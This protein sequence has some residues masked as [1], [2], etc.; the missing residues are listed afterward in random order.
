MSSPPAADTDDDAS[1]S[2]P[3]PAPSPS[4]DLPP[5]R[6][7]I[8]ALEQRANADARLPRVGSFGG[9]LRHRDLFA[10]EPDG[11]VSHPRYVCAQRVW[12]SGVG[13]QVFGLGA[14]AGTAI[15]LPPR[16]RQLGP[17]HT[18]PPQKKTHTQKHI[19]TA[20][21]ALLPTRPPG[22]VARPRG[23]GLRLQACRA[24]A[25]PARGQRRRRLRAARRHLSWWW[26]EARVARPS[27]WTAR[28]SLRVT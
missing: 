16:V 8:A 5:V 7:R 9:R 3:P 17:P 24:A 19:P 13:A 28:P 20:P 25:A 12:T 21:P 23:A 15:G 27:L 11:R 18:T 6:S 22:L 26:M 14:R 10:P 1:S 2:P 4:P